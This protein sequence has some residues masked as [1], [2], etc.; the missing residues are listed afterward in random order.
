[1][2]YSQSKRYK[3]KEGYSDAYVVVLSNSEGSM[4]AIKL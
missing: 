1:M 2:N 3:G 4:R